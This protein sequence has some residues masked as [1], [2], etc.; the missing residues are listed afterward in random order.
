M[1]GLC[2]YMMEQGDNLLISFYPLLSSTASV[3]IV[4]IP[5]GLGLAY[6]LIARRTIDTPLALL[7]IP[8]VIYGLLQLALVAWLERGPDGISALLPFGLILVAVVAGLGI[9]GMMMLAKG[10]HSARP[11]P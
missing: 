11:I 5:W 8:L 7:S 9:V 3:F 2:N 1:D 10:Y 4:A 6:V